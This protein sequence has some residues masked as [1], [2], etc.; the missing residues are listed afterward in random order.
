MN[1]FV[2]NLRVLWTIYVLQLK[3]MIVDG[4]V[5]FTVILQPLLVALLAIY[6]LRDAEG[7]QAIYVI[8]G[9]A[10]TGLWAGTIY[11]TSRGIEFERSSGTLEETIGSPTPL[12][13][14]VIGKACSNLTLALSSMLIS[15]PAAAWLFGFRLTIAEPVLFAVS[16]VLTLVALVSMGLAIAPIFSMNPGLF[17]WSDPLEFSVYALSGFLFPIALLPLWLSPFS[18]LLAPY[19]AAR[20]IHLTSSGGSLSEVWLSWGL[21]IASCVA[22]WFV[23]VWL[24][25][26]L[27]NRAREHATL[28]WQ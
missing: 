7:F 18:Y 8:V 1:L 26:V 10:M 17:M 27:L 28:S 15:Y 22:Y 14:V 21:L 19:W 20:A 11:I 25:R 13:V 4:W 12:A 5:L 3:Q 23:A 9:S 6:M 2:Q 16:I 24:F